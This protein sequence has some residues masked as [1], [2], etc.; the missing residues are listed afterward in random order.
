MVSSEKLT[1]DVSTFVAK[2]VDL[3]EQCRYLEGFLYLVHLLKCIIR[4]DRD[5]D[6]QLHLHTVQKILPI[7]H[8]FD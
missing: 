3:S 7:F 4:A 6:W 8:V 5:G 1:G 2:A